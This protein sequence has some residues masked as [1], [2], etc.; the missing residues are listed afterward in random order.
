MIPEQKDSHKSNHI[1]L[2][3]KMEP[4]GR[5]YKKNCIHMYLK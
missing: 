2:R 4:L 5:S 1:Q 3:L